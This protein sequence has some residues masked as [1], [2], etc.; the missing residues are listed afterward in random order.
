[1][2]GIMF[3]EEF[4][5]VKKYVGGLPDMVQGSV[6]ASKPKTMQEAI[7]FATDLMDQK[8][9][10][11]SKRQAKNKRKL[12]DKTWNNHTQQQ[13][14]KRKNIARAYTDGPGD[15]REYG[16]SL[17]LCTKCNYH[18]NGKC[19]PKCNNCKKAG[20]L[21][22]D[23]RSHAFNANANNQ[24]NFRVIQMVVTCFECGDQG[25]YKKDFP[26]MKNNNRGNLAGNGGATTMAYAMG[27]ARKNL[28][29]NVI[30]EALFMDLMN[31]VCKPYL[32]KFMI[33][34][35]DDIPIYSKRKQDHE[36]HLK[37]ILELLKK[38]EL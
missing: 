31:R 30:T 3:L 24:R 18:H 14:H 20:H 27:Y 15:K 10:I 38:E 19:A 32:D 29:S 17:P 36:E 21:A 6:T 12:D 1:M 35:I 16:G 11:F 33:V 37:L 26:K 4:D 5:E 28:D 22:R 23:Y 2:C 13:P 34:F 25:H 7:E 9:R 8:I